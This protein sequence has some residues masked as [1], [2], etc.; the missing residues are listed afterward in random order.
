MEE[1]GPS[2]DFQGANVAAIAEQVVNEAHP[3][4][5]VAVHYIGEP[6][7]H[8]LLAEVEPRYIHRAI[9]NLVG[10]AG[11]YANS[12]SECLARSAV[13]LAVGCRGRPV[14]AFR[15]ALGESLCRLC[16]QDDSRTRSSGGYGLGLSIVRRIAHWHGG[17]AM[18]TRSDTQAV[19]VS[20]IIWPP[21]SE[22]R[23]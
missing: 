7:E 12:K 15:G 2:L 18:V 13:K 6:V 20:G 23:E 16:A 11:R 17:R 21:P 22:R 14:L 5:H 19:R 1:G 3:P 4:K 10:N 8:C 9:Q